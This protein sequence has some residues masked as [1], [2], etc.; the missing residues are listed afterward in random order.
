MRTRKAATLIE[1][2]LIILFI[3]MALTIVISILRLISIYDYEINE[4]QQF[5]AILQ[6]RKRVALGSE[7]RVEEDR[8]KMVFN[9][10]EIELICEGDKVVEREGYMEY[11]TEL[12]DCGWQ[13]KDG[14]VFLRYEYE[15]N[16]FRVFIGY[17]A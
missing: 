7:L 16:P 11:L 17:K 13:I 4:R 14:L 10:R 15:S 9:N 5:I 8:L 3:P 1:M 6:L 12:E 2:L